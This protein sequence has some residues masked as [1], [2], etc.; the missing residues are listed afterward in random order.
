M[1]V[2][3][4]N[5]TS[6]GDAPAAPTHEDGTPYTYEMIYAGGSRR[7]YADGHVELVGLLIEGYPASG[8]PRELMKARI[9]QAMDWQVRLQAQINAG[10]REQMA[11]CDEQQRAI[12]LGSRDVPP[13]PGQ[14][15]CPIPLVLVDTFYKP[16]GAVP[17]PTVPDGADTL[18]WL[19]PSDDWSL[20]VSGH[21]AGAISV[22]AAGPADPEAR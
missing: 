13:A 22:F 20:L 2:S 21:S 7:G 15:D 12:L 6:A 3:I 16:I 17:R 10:R 9:R 5:T 4:R 1:A 14:W 19:D 8:S 11:E 18:I